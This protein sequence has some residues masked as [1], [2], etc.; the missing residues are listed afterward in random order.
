[1]QRCTCFA[2]E[3]RFKSGWES[4][5][6]E[7]SRRGR[8]NKVWRR[9]WYARCF[10]PKRTLRTLRTSLATI[11]YTTIFIYSNI[12]HKFYVNNNDN[13]ELFGV[14][15]WS[16]VVIKGDILIKSWTTS[17]AQWFCTMGAGWRGRADLGNELYWS[18]FDQSVLSNVLVLTRQIQG[19][20]KS[21]KGKFHWWSGTTEMATDR[22]FI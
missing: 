22:T 14:S 1:M 20:P 19:I 12:N 6:N 2:N 4:D 7:K 21:E 11:Q 16:E 10:N 15:L 17:M 8:H 13:F 9:G 5:V 3:V 18:G